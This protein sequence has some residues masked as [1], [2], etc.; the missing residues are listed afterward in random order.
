MGRAGIEP[1]T[2]G[3]RM[4]RDIPESLVPVRALSGVL[5]WVNNGRL[6]QGPVNSR[7]ARM[8][9]PFCRSFVVG[10]EVL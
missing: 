7:F 6:T 9:P 4:Y 3:L 2:L 8:N 1:E 5:G 10:R